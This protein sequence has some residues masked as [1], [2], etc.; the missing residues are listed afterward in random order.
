MR[1]GLLFAKQTSTVVPTTVDYKYTIR[2]N[3]WNGHWFS[4]SLVNYCNNRIS[5]ITHAVQNNASQCETELVPLPTMFLIKNRTIF[6]NARTLLILLPSPTPDQSEPCPLDARITL[7]THCPNSKQNFRTAARTF[8]PPRKRPQHLHTT[9]DPPS[10]D[11]KL[12]V[13]PTVRVGSWNRSRVHWNCCSRWCTVT[14]DK[15]AKLENNH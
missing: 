2:K 3:R 15:T 7:P 6:A 9:L 10:T 11:R 14:K 1:C 12:Q 5:P 13:M 4:F 8:H